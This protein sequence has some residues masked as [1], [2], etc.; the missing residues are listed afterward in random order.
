MRKFLLYITAFFLL[1]ATGCNLLSV[2][3][4]I[5]DL[6]KVAS[7]EKGP[8][9]GTCPVFTLTIYEKGVAAYEGK[10]FTDRKGLYVKKLEQD[11]F[12]DLVNAFEKADLWKYK[13]VYR[14]NIPDFQTVTISYWKGDD[15]K[16]VTGKDGRP[17]A[18]L[19]LEDLMDAIAQ[20]TTDW[21]L[22]E[23]AGY[24]V[25][26]NAIA[27]ELIIQLNSEVKAEVWSRQFAKQDMELI[28]RL[29]P[30]SPYWLFHF[31]ADK[32]DPNEMLKFVRQDP[33]VD[34]AEFN[35]KVNYR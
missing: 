23:A 15:M 31:N 19:E 35:K 13:N 4:N 11:V 5:E 6:T 34:S 12:N 17:E 32:I 16:S 18:I 14:G 33:Y 28:K 7:M 21:K 29:A 20:D 27:D 30:E 3:T 26:E 8:C 2:P 24:D 25:P 9:Y 10:R 22:K 1:N